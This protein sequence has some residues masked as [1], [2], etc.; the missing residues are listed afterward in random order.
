MWASIFELHRSVAQL[1]IRVQSAT[2]ASDEG[3]V[4]RRGH[5][6]VAVS[7]LRHPSSTVTD[8]GCDCRCYGQNRSLGV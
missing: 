5:L 6:W 4:S 8:F 3:G 2:N 1:D 7:S